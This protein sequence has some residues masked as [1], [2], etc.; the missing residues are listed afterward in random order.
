MRKSIYIKLALA[1]MLVALITSGLIAVFIRITSA[2][3][4]F[5]L[6]VDQ[7]S[8]TME[9]GAANYY[10]ASGSWDGVDVVWNQIQPQGG[11]MIVNFAGDV[12]PNAP[13][14]VFEHRSLFGLADAN[15]KV[16][17]PIGPYNQIGM[18]LSNRQLKSGT[19]VIV[20][21]IQV[22]T[23]LTADRFSGYNPAE[24]LF[25]QRTNQGLVYAML[26]ALGV[27]LVLGLLFARSFARPLQELTKAAR[28]MAHGELEQKVKATSQDEIG[29]LALAFNQMSQEVASANQQRRQMTADIAHDLRTPLTVI[30]GYVESMRDGI[31]KPTPERLTVIYT[32]IERLQQMVTDL[33]MLSQADAGELH[34]NPQ[35]VAPRLLL[36]RAAELFQHHAERQNVHLAIQIEGDV[37]EIKVDESRMMQVMDNLI[38]NAL[39]YTPEGGKITL[40][41]H[42]KENSVELIVQDTGSGIPAEEIP[43]IF[44]RFHRVEKSRHAEEG[45]SGLGLA[46]VKALVE[47]NGGQIWAESEEGKGTTMHMAFPAIT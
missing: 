15:G 17:V 39:H 11:A 38:S 16:V 29:E 19:S 2:D 4:L 21:E 7:Q 47:A 20:N 32:E 33:R 10:S 27:A 46:I 9:Q 25:L 14:D 26:G 13:R 22:G 42:K 44:N 3:R 45:E 37:P 1:F 23:I 18:Q 24:T 5:K 41:A 34:L 30:A 43:M 40:G 6:V 36:E 8:D 35:P 12:P 28:A 31:L